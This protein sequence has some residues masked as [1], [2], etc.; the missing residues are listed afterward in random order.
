M[1][2]PGY[3]FGWTPAQILDQCMSA[4]NLPMVSDILPIRTGFRSRGKLHARFPKHHSDELID[5]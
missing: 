4:M 1:H 2:E 3:S 5:V